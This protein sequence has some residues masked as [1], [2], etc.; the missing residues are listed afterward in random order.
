MNAHERTL[1][2]EQMEQVDPIPEKESLEPTGGVSGEL[3]KNVNNE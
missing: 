1:Q 3:Q 2:G